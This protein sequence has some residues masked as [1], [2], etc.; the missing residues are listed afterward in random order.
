MSVADLDQARVASDAP[1]KGLVGDLQAVD[2]A[3]EGWGPVRRP[4]CHGV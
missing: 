4:P 2:D 3:F 1:D